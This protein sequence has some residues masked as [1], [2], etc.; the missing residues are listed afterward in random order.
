MPRRTSPL[1]RN[2]LQHTVT[3][4]SHGIR[5]TDTSM[6]FYASCRR[7]STA[8]HCSTL[9]HTATHCNT[10]H[11][12]APHCITQHN[13]ATHVNTLQLFNTLQHTATHCNTLQHSAAQC[14]TVHTATHCNT[15]QHSAAQCSTVQQP[16][17]CYMSTAQEWTNRT[18]ISHE[19]T[20]VH[21]LVLPGSLL[22]ITEVTEYRH[23]SPFKAFPSIKI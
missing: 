23:F 1:L 8:T 17:A 15:L 2:T 21:F 6:L 16:K 10:L 3:P 20:S 5:Q 9:Q 18:L 11:H 14:S 4:E 19:R 12:T 22:S 13:I 7:S